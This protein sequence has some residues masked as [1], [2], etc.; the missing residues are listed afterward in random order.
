MTDS[1]QLMIMILIGFCSLAVAGRSAIVSS[2]AQTS[3]TQ[4][5]QQEQQQEQQQQ[6]QQQHRE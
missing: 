5:Q 2:L 6:E 1:S 3:A 4:P